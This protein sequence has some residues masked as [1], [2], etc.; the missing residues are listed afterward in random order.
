MWDYANLSPQQHS[1]Q[2]MSFGSFWEFFRGLFSW[3]VKNRP[4]GL[5][6]HLIQ[7][8]A[9]ATFYDAASVTWPVHCLLPWW[10]CHSGLET[11]HASSF[12]P[13]FQFLGHLFCNFLNAS[14][15]PEWSIFRRI[16][17]N[18][19]NTREKYNGS[20]LMIASGS[21]HFKS[22]T[23]LI[24]KRK[25]K[26]PITMIQTKG[27]LSGKPFDRMMDSRNFNPT[28]ETGRPQLSPH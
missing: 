21:G 8:A 18:L 5:C 24:L 3:I 26:Y 6:H 2:K 14:W 28:S 15:R 17:W 19:G 27:C 22:W 20:K 4:L 9:F 7:L 25:R 1:C 11:A 16:Y 10:L 13:S 12:D 23:G